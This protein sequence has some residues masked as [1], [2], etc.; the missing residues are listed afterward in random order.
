MQPMPPHFIV[1]QPALLPGTRCYTDAATAPDESMQGTQ[2][3]WI[4]SFLLQHQLKHL[5]FNLHK[6]YA[7]RLHLRANG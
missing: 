2:K 7:E 5:I 6:S 3:S 1:T 4:G